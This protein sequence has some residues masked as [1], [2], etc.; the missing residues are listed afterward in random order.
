MSVEMLDKLLKKGSQKGRRLEF[1][2]EEQ[3]ERKVQ[4]VP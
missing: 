2:R 4:E 1:K 3:Q